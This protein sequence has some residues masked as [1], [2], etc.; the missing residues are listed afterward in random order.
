MNR[1]TY[2]SLMLMLFASVLVWQISIRI[3][4]EPN[5]L[6]LQGLYQPYSKVTFLSRHSKA[7]L[8]SVIVALTLS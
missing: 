5:Q 6:L 4:A 2:Y 7:Q 8:K 3:A 1:K